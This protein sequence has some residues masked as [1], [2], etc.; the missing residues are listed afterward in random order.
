VNLYPL[1]S[2]IVRDYRQMLWT[3]L[4]AVGA[5]LAVGCGNLAGLMLVRAAGRRPELVLRTALG[6]SRRRIVRQLAVEALLLASLGGALGIVIAHAGL[7][8]WRAWGPVNFPRLDEVAID[9]CWP[10]RSRY[11]FW[12]WSCVESFRHLR[13]REIW[14]LPS[15]AVGGR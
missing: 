8:V 11:R 10:L 6:G 2:E 5:L 12:W 14:R 7:A 3:L 1:H 9:E 13:R 4:A 15:A